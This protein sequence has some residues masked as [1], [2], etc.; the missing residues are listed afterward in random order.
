MAK[1]AR[2]VPPEFNW[3]NDKGVFDMERH[4]RCFRN[5]LSD[6]IC[7]GNALR[8]VASA[9]PVKYVIKFQRLRL[10]NH[11]AQRFLFKVERIMEGTVTVSAAVIE[12]IV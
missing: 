3:N 11:H 10:L 9:V 7:P 6:H 4:G 5:R 2:V 12:T 1:T 8:R